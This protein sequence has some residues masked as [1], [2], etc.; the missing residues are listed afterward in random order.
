[1]SCRHYNPFFEGEALGT[2]LR[3]LIADAKL[4]SHSELE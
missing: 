1:M 4:V 3:Q 2:R